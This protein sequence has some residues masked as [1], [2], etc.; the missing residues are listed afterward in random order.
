[1]LMIY[2]SI[3]ALAFQIFDW[4]G[5]NGLKLNPKKSQVILIYR[6][7]VQFPQP[8]LYIGSDVIRVVT[9]VNNLGFVLIGNLTAVD[10]SKGVCRGIYTILRSIRPHASH[11]PF[12]IRGRLVQS[13]ATK[14]ISYGNIMYSSVDVA[15]RGR[16]RVAFNACLRYIHSVRPRDHIS[17]LESSVTG[18]SLEISARAQFLIYF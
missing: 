14:H 12:P 9:F 5:A 18:M 10:H 17:H 3:T 8:E 15:S 16:I 2:K 13:L 1:M 6:S 11:T 7:G 4:A